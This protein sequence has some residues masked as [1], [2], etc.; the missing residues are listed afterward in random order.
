MAMKELSHGEIK[1]ELPNP[2]M[3]IL[4]D[5]NKLFTKISERTSILQKHLF[6]QNFANL[7]LL[8]EFLEE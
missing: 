8:L 7:N 4:N 3:G 5:I 6:S 1:S 2:K